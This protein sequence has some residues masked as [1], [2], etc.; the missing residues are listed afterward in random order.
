VIPDSSKQMEIMCGVCHSLTFFELALE[1]LYDVLGVACEVL[2][3]LELKLFFLAAD[4]LLV[5]LFEAEQFIVVKAYKF[6]MCTHV[7]DVWHKYTNS[8]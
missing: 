5:T 2:F 6:F 4:S 8:K 7:S 1:V 3:T